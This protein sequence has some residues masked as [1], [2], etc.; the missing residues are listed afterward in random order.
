MTVCM[1]LCRGNY[2]GAWVA[3][4]GYEPVAELLFNEINVDG[5]FLEYDSER[6]GGFEPLRFLPKGKIAVL[7]LVTTK[8]P[9]LESKDDAEAPH[10]RGGA[11][12]A[13]R[14]ARAQPAMR[15]R[16]RHRRQHHD[17][18]AA[19]GE[20]AADR[21]DGARGVG[22]QVVC[23]WSRTPNP[24]PPLR[25]GRGAHCPCRGSSPRLNTPLLRHAGLAQP[26]DEHVAVGERLQ[27]RAQHATAAAAG[28]CGCAG[29]VFLRLVGSPRWP[30]QLISVL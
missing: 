18:R 29:D 13:A 15:L 2:A 23:C 27:V 12:R 22:K 17:D 24:S 26:L 25:G 16:E 10:R 11:L 9:Q 1:H 8:S 14:A 6:A 21:R 3:E 30:Q 20:A 4:G 28:R 7:G 5:Y 19:D